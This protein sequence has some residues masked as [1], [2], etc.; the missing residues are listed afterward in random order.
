MNDICFETN[1]MIYILIQIKVKIIKMLFNSRY[2][3]NSVN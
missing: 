3:T 2:L 1:H